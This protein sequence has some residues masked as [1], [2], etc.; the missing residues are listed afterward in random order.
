MITVVNKRYHLGGGVYLGR[1][2]LLGNPFR[3]GEH[4]SDRQV[5]SLAL[6]ADSA[7]RPCLS[8]TA[9]PG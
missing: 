8:G 6:A 3:I 5:S 4:G 2:S 7:A 9:L 1:P